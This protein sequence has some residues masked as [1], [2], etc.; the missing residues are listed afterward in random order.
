M[1]KFWFLPV[2]A[3]AILVAG[4]SPAQAK[5]P[6]AEVSC[7]SAYGDI[8]SEGK[9][10][11]PHRVIDGA[12]INNV[13]DFMR[14]TGTRE[15]GLKIINGGDFSGWDFSNIPLANICFENGN[16]TDANFAGAQARGIGF[17]KSDLT[18]S[19]MRGVRMPGIFFRNANLSDVAAQGADFSGGHFDGGWFEGGVGGW[20]IDGANL[21]G[22]IFDCGITISDGCPVYQGE[23][24]ISAKGTNFTRTTLHSFGLYNVDLSG[25]LLDQ[26]IV[27]PRQ[28]SN[29]VTA[30][31]GGNIILRGSENDVRLTADEAKYLL[32]E[33]A[34]QKKAEARPSFDCAKAAS[35]VE[36]EICGEYADDLRAADRDIASLYQRAK[37]SS[38]GVKSSQ[39]AWLKQRN[40]CGAAEYPSGCIR[41]SYS[42]RKGEL[43]GLLGEDQWLARGEAALFIDDLLPLP[44]EIVASD[45]FAKIAPVLVGASMTDILIERGDDGLFTI[46]GNAV[47]ANAHLCSIN[48]AHLYFDKL[49]GWYIPVS[50]GAAVPIFRIYDDRLEIFANGRPD[51]ETHPEAADLM[52]C[53]MRASL[54]ETVRVRVSDEIIA[55]YRKSLSQEM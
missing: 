40:L 47:G 52:S 18:G 51:Y 53:G 26:T 31:F 12:S 21:T 38:P 39:R 8:W 48:A 44:A 5:T 11:V 32:A 17:I 15:A 33:T 24:G 37:Q 1:T 45:L 4:A 50:E 19:N 20:N 42:L 16:L 35:K 54:G 22:F 2:A 25:A 30:E 34:R 6:P 10:D 13:P 49:S 14:M 9:I 7:A 3:L 29:L 27:G 43:L 41:E 28:L 23:A 36:L 46:K 55:D